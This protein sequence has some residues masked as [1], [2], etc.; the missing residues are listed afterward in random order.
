MAT[1]KCPVCGVT[2]NLENLDRHVRDRHPR[3]KVDLDQTLTQA[4]REALTA[5]RAARRPAMTR[6]GKRLVAVAAIALAAVVLVIALNPFGNAGIAPGQTAPDFT[7][8][9]SDGGSLTLSALRGHPAFLEFMDIDCP[10]CINAASQVLP[11]LYQNYGSRV[12]FVS[13]DINFLG[14]ADTA[15]RIEAFKAQYGT[16]WPHVMDDGSAARSYGVA[17]TPTCYVLD[18]NGRVVVSFVGEQTYAT[19][20]AGLDRA[21]GG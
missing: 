11:T 15:D 1:A 16:N 2:V 10:H 19:F 20:A 9:R 7:L 13:V 4:E 5:T 14:A 12:N 21:L 17:S 8:P 6:R 3:A 18:A